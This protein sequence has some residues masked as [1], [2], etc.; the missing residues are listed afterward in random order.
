MK[1]SKFSVD[2]NSVFYEVFDSRSSI[3]KNSGSISGTPTFRN[4]SGTFSSGDSV[5]YG[6]KIKSVKTISFYVTLDTGTEDI[7]DFDGGTHTITVSGGTISANGFSTPIICVDGD[8][9]STITTSRSLVTVSTDTAFDV[10]ALQIGGTFDGI[11]EKLE[12]FS[13]Y[14]EEKD[15]NNLYS[16]KLY[17]NDE[18]KVGDDFAIVQSLF[19][20]KGLGVRTVYDCSGNGNDASLVQSNCLTFSGTGNVNYGDSDNFSMTDGAG[21]DLPFSVA[22]WI[23][24]SNPT[25][26]QQNLVSKIDRGSNST[27]E[28]SISFTSTTGCILFN[29]I[30]STTGKIN[31]TTLDVALTADTDY[32][33]ICV[34]DG[35]ESQNGMTIYVNNVAVAQTKVNTGTYN[36]MNNTSCNF[37]VASDYTSGIKSNYYL[38][39]IWDVRVWKNHVLTEGERTSVYGGEI[40]VAADTLILH[41]PLAEGSGSVA[42]N[43]KNDALHGTITNGTWGNK[44]DYFHYNILNGFDFYDS[45]NDRYLCVWVC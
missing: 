27:K 2:K 17:L 25:L 32:H 5:S 40:S 10:T 23:N 15:S 21:N 6:Q 14:F 24:P 42:Y 19:G 22:F 33:I 9:T 13:D 7:L 34:Y 16:N 1:A 3:I 39:S 41:S 12:M 36:G 28:W 31:K 30:D 29:C 8:E 4:G 20:H 11:I 35:S 26:Q 37:G 44:Q 38:G 45:G 18:R 43:V